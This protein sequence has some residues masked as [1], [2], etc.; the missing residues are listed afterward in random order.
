ML[1]NCQHVN[2]LKVFKKNNKQDKIKK[3]TPEYCPCTICKKNVKDLSFCNTVDSVQALFYFLKNIDFM[4][5]YK[6][7]KTSCV[8]LL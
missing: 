4:Y 6:R 8:E 7:S 5:Y 3:W 2:S 1:K